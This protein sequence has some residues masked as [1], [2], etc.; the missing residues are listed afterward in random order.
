MKERPK[1]IGYRDLPEGLMKARASSSSDVMYYVDGGTWFA[2]T[3]D[4][5]DTWKW[6]DD[7]GIWVMVF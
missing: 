6:R 3:A 5:F 1:S 7:Q 2:A 4:S